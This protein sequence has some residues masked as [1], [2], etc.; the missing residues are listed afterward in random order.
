[1]PSKIFIFKNEDH[2]NNYEIYKDSIPENLHFSLE[3]KRA[4]Y[5][6]AFIETKSVGSAK[7]IFDYVNRSL[8][9]GFFD[10]PDCERVAK[11][12]ANHLLKATYF[13]LEND[14][15]MFFC[16]AVQLSFSEIGNCDKT[17]FFNTSAEFLRI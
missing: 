2:E 11:A 15:L 10:N 4:I 12:L 3:L 1:M 6:I 14:W 9:P 8:S 7:Y 16:E 17:D 5:F 13:A